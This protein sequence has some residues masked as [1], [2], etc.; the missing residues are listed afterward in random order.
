MALPPAAQY[1][2]VM[3]NSLLSFSLFGT[4]NPFDYKPQLTA[5]QWLELVDEAASQG[6]TALLYDAVQKLPEEQRPPR[7]ELF[8]LT[9]TT[10]TIE[11][12]N[13]RRHATLLH[14]ATLLQQQ[15]D[16]TPVVVKGSSLARLYP[17]PLHRECGDNDIFT[18]VDTAR[19]NGYAR[20]LGVDVDESNF[21]HSYFSFHGVDFECHHRLLYREKEPQWRS[22]PWQT[23]NEDFGSSDSGFS[24]S[25]DFSNV[26]LLRRLVPEQ[27]ARFLAAHMEYHAVFF[28]QPIR[29]RSLID[30]T[31]LLL[32]PDMDYE[33]LS[34]EM[35]GTELACFVHLLSRYCLHRFHFDNGDI[36]TWQQL[37]M[38]PS[39]FEQLYL[40]IAPRH[41]NPIVRVSRR[42]LHYLRYARLYRRI[43]GQSMFRRFYLSNIATAVRNHL[44][45]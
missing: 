11:Q 8:Q 15:L 18:G 31:L 1:L 40:H 24:D 41:P 27:E 26:S 32:S 14:F 23:G 7:R 19:V 10:M 3:L 39:D 6:V 25:T 21:R 12:D 4:T 38:T 2:P 30:W 43:Y 29:L 9:S 17:V 45:R 33:K 20:S 16:I 34:K 13:S 36:P 42:S 37:G 44:R 22:I 28:H 35:Q 5:A